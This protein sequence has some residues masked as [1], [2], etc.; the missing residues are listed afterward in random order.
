[1][2]LNLDAENTEFVFEIILHE[3]TFLFM[4]LRCSIINITAMKCV[5]KLV[6]QLPVRKHMEKKYIV[7]ATSLEDRK[8]K[9]RFKIMNLNHIIHFVLMQTA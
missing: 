6:P 3:E 1:M 7:F 8:K 4:L 9:C 5:L 2:E